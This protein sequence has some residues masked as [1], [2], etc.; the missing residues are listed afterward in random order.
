MSDY[1]HDEMIEKI[2]ECFESKTED[3]DNPELIEK[4]FCEVLPEIGGEMKKYRRNAVLLKKKDTPA[5]GI[6]VGA[7]K[8]GGYPDLP[9]GVEYPTMTGYSVRQKR[10]DSIGETKPTV[11]MHLVLQLN[12]RE[13]AE[14]GADIDGLFPKTGMLYI[15]W[16]GEADDNHFNYYRKN[17]GVYE[18]KVDDTSKE[19]VNSIFWWDGDISQLKRTEPPIPYNDDAFESECPEKMIGFDKG[20]EYDRLGVIDGFSDFADDLDL[21]Y[22]YKDDKLLGF[23][24]G[25]NNPEIGDE[26]VQLMQLDYHEGCIWELYWIM[27]KDELL[28]LDFSNVSLECDCD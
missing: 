2:I 9:P 28:R 18:L 20:Y 12:C 19:N 17:S 25:A 3:P 22:T 10:T 27:R 26:Y 5:G 15:F 1:S 23:P 24:D 8:M 13:L 6:P 16:S 14:S 21:E 7:S 4:V 11:A